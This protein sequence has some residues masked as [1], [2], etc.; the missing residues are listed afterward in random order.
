MNA[1][2]RENGLVP[3]RL[4]LG[5]IMGFFNFEFKTFKKEKEIKPLKFV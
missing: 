3:S 2:M 4:G 5:V 1:T